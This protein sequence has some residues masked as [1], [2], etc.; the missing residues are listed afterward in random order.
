MFNPPLSAQ[1]TF[2]PVSAPSKIARP[3]LTQWVSDD[4]TG[5]TLSFAQRQ[6]SRRVEQLRIDDPESSWITPSQ[7]RP[8]SPA[9]SGSP[10]PAGLSGNPAQA[11]NGLSYHG[12]GNRT[13]RFSGGHVGRRPGDQAIKGPAARA[14]GQGAQARKAQ[15]QPD[16]GLDIQAEA[17]RNERAERAQGNAGRKLKAEKYSAKE[18]EYKS[19]TS[20]KSQARKERERKER[21]H[22]I[23]GR[24]PPPERKPQRLSLGVDS[25]LAAAQV[26]PSEVVEAEL[27]S[28]RKATADSVDKGSSMVATRILRMKE[29][30]GDYSRFLPPGLGVHPPA[31]G[32]LFEAEKGRLGPAAYAQLTLTRRRGVG[33]RRREEVVKIVE[34]YVKMSK[35]VRESAQV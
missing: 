24:K 12:P 35:G 11:S 28:L 10:R 34:R 25:M 32:R 9:K 6:A 5:V 16:S 3:S 18:A 15:S 22:P 27:Q 21:E 31:L 7:S 26:N 29:R 14:G 2:S 1:Y 19:K 8:V 30:A 4:N 20:I 13:G 23:L 17:R 33:L